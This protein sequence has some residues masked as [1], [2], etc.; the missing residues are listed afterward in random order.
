MDGDTSRV[1]KRPLKDLLRPHGLVM[2]IDNADLPVDAFSPCR[3]LRGGSAAVV[4][5]DLDISV[6]GNIP[7]IETRSRTTRDILDGSGGRLGIYL[8]QHRIFLCAVEIFWKD[9]PPIHSHIVFRG[10]LEH[11]YRILGTSASAI[12]PAA[13]LL[14]RLYDRM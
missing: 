14:V 6:G 3:T 11:F 10:D 7:G 8:E 4:Q 5:A 9:H 12:A 1:D 13:G 2:D